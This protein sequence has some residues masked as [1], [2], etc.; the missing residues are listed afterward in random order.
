MF[1]EKGV[2][3]SSP[4]ILESFF[5]KPIVAGYSL[6]SIFEYWWVGLIILIVAA[7]GLVAT[8]FLLAWLFG[9]MKYKD[10]DKETVKG[11]LQDT[12]KP[13]FFLEKT[14]NLIVD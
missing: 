14:F 2:F 6:H 13:S 5:D 3:M 9:R 7:V 10:G 11:I 4:L 12:L 8:Y 1:N